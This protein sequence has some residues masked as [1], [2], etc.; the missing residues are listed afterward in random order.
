MVFL[1]SLLDEFV[2]SFDRVNGLS[3]FEFDVVLLIDF[4][5]KDLDR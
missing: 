1:G 3:I 5:A 4:S 2:S